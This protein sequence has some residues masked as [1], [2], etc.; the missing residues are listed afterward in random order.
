MNYLNK[1]KNYTSFKEFVK[2]ENKV[3]VKLS[4][5][6]LLDEATTHMSDRRL[7]RN[8]VE[9][10]EIIKRYITLGDLIKNDYGTYLFIKKNNLEHLIS[11]LKSRFNK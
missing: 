9:V 5:L 1:V 11:H 7:R 6:H 4:H 2:L 3:Y 8:E 10:K